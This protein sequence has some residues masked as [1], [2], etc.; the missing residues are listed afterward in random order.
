MTPVGGLQAVTANGTSLRL[1][2]YLT[3]DA[4]DA[5][6]TAGSEEG[7]ATILLHS[8]HQMPGT[9]EEV[10]AG[11]MR[12]HHVP[13][14]SEFSLRSKLRLARCFTNSERRLQW[15]RVQVTATTVLA[16]CHAAYNAGH[17][18]VNE[19]QLSELMGLLHSEGEEASD[20]SHPLDLQTLALKALTALLCERSRA[21]AALRC[22]RQHCT[23][24]LMYT[25]VRKVGVDAAE[26]LRRR[27]R[28]AL[29]TASQCPHV[30]ISGTAS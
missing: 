26:T 23:P 24:A 4:D 1:Q 22:T 16:H 12:D 2:Y 6:A 9:D 21:T 10:Y 19:A 28:A 27:R 18:T 15:V 30:R 8:V 17:V 20:G 14:E 7:A 13:K 5:A 3:L 29:P 11:V 25:L